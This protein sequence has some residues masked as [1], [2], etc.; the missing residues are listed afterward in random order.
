MNLKVL[1]K[2]KF[3]FDIFFLIIANNHPRSQSNSTLKFYQKIKL[4]LILNI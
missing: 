4:K 1:S 3:D 2:Y